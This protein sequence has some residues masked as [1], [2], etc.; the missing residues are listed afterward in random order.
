ME[1]IIKFPYC[2]FGLIRL[3]FPTCLMKQLEDYISIHESKWRY[4]FY[5][6]AEAESK[7]LFIFLVQAFCYNIVFTERINEGTQIYLWVFLPQHI[8]LCGTNFWDN[9]MHTKYLMNVLVYFTRNESFLFFIFYF[10]F[11]SSV[12]WIYFLF[13]WNKA[14]M[15][16]HMT[17]L[18]SSRWSQ[19]FRVDHTTK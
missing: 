10:C 11:S 13:W 5:Y 3:P 1:E 14:P 18:K 17:L 2:C 12:S 15:K 8:V 7:G 6:F 9:I 19:M 4:L 16:V